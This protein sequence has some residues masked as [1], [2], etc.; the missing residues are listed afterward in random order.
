ML[1]LPIVLLLPVFPIVFDDPVPTLFFYAGNFVSEPIVFEL[2]FGGTGVVFVAVVLIASCFGVPVLEVPTGLVDEELLDVV[3][4]FFYT[5]GVFATVFF[6][7]STFDSTLALVAV[8]VALLA[9][10]LLSVFCT[11]LDAV[12]FIYNTNIYYK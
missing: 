1:L 6:A 3:E 9:V 2:A 4:G 5:F 10:V 12:G 8:V 11:L 7:G